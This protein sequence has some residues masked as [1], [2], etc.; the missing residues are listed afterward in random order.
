MLPS[1]VEIND[2]LLRQVIEYGHSRVP[3][4]E[5]SRE[6]R[7]AGLGGQGRGGSCMHVP[8]VREP[9]PKKQAAASAPPGYHKR[10]QAGLPALTLPAA[11]NIVGLIL[12]KELVLVD[13]DAG[14]R[15]RDLRLR[16][17]PFL[18]WGGAAGREASGL[19]I[20]CA[21]LVAAC[22]AG[23][24]LPAQCRRCLPLHSA[25][26]HTCTPFSCVSSCTRTYP[27]SHSAAEPTPRCTACFA[28][29]APHA[30]TWRC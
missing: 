22:A 29:S 2:E 10:E 20:M 13:E 17:V 7:R 4:Y 9:C 21:E 27:L 3:V 1:D 18:R 15:V 8:R 14:V 19:S 12:V 30:A 23:A 24:F 16:E 28:C 25:P 5:G 26:W 6:V 11:Q